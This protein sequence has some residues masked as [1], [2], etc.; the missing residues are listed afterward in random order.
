MVEVGPWQCPLTLAEQY[1]ETRAGSSAYQGSFLLH[2]LDAMVWPN[3]PD[4][5]ITGVAV[6][7]CILNLGIYGRRLRGW[8]LSGRARR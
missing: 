6:G 4:G 5:A 2:W 7:I 1:L 3:L 8:I